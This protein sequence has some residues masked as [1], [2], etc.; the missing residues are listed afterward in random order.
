MCPDIFID[1]KAKE[2]VDALSPGQI[3]ISHNIGLVEF[4]VSE[5]ILF[6]VTVLFGFLEFL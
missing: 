6:Y 3:I 1:P 5:V 4:K 2:S